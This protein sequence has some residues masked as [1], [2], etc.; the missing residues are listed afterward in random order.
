[1]TNAKQQT[2]DLGVRP[3]PILERRRQYARLVK[4]LGTNST[5]M[6]IGAPGD[7]PVTLSVGPPK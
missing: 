2:D 3:V 4:L 6:V 5:I 1:M 7:M